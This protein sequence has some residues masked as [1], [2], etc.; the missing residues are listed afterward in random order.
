MALIVQKYGGTSVGTIERITFYNPENHFAI[1]TFRP[2]KSENTIIILGTLPN[3]NP[4]EK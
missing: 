4:R 1:A 2:L 3:P